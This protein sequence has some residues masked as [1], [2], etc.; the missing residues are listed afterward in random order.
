MLAELQGDNAEVAGRMAE[1]H[2]LCDA[3]PTPLPRPPRRLIDEA[4]AALVLFEARRPER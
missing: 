4:A 3:M 2:V 1:V